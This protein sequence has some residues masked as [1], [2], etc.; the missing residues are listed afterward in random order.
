MKLSRHRSGLMLAIAV[1]LFVA[2]GNV[3]AEPTLILNLPE[4][5]ADAG[6]QDIVIPVYLTNVDDTIAGFTIWMQLNRPD[7]CEIEASIDTT[8]TLISGWEF[9]D[10][11][12]LSGQPFDL[13]VSGL[14]N[15]P[16]PPST[17][18][19]TPQDGSIP[20]FRIKLDAYDIS[21]TVTD[22][23]AIIMIQ[24]QNVSHFSFSDPA[25]N[26]LGIIHD[27][28]PDTNLFRCVSWQGDICLS[29]I[30][31]YTPPFDSL[32]ID[33]TIT[34]TID[35]EMVSVT[36]GLF[37]ISLEFMCGDINNDDGPIVDIADLVYMV[38]YMFTGGPEPLVLQSADVNASGGV[39]DIGDL[40]FLVDFMF[41]GGPDLVCP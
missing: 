20:L 33:T 8:G 7:I 29:W 16:A 9:T 14:A 12:S 13:K 18:Y 22:R 15:L 23:T 39:I 11:R 35:P 17:P 34:T 5:S 4:V 19:L 24:D 36:D 1:W 41:T 2:S 31:V 37:T 6:Q 38:D 26:S 28:I 40:V 32:D 25:G 27:T 3:L 21:D 10:S 30:Q